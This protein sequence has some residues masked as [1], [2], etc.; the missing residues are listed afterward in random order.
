MIL[1]EGEVIVFPENIRKGD[2]INRREQEDGEFTQRD[3]I[4]DMPDGSPTGLE[5]IG[6]RMTRIERI[7]TDLYWKLKWVLKLLNSKNGF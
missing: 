1:L 6:T 5:R 3:L 2:I 4:I 7:R